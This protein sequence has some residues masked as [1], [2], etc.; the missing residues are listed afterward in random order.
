LKLRTV[1]IGT[2][3][4]LGAVTGAYFVWQRNS[5]T[6]VPV[7][8][9]KTHGRLEATRITISAKNQGRLAE[10]LVREGDT[11]DA[12]QVVARMDARSL[13][14]QLR[15]AEAQ[16]RRTRDAKATASAAVTQR[17]SELT[18]AKRQYDRSR[19]AY[20]MGAGSKQ[21]VDVDQSKSET[22]AAALKSARSQ[23]VEAESAIEAADAE[24]ERLKVEIE[25]CDL[26]APVHARVQYRLAEPGEV[27]AAGGRVLDLIDLTD[28]YMIVYL[29]ETEAG[30][31]ALGAEARVI[32]DAAPDAV[33]PASVSYVAA[34]AQFTPKTVE[35]ATERQKLAFQV[36]VRI[37]ADLLRRYELLVKTG[38]P[39]TVYV[40][41]DSKTEWPDHLRP[42]LPREPPGA[43]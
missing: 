25:D 15:Q 33:V 31:T 3:L 2:V 4:V 21:D 24:V 18:L 29:P 6:D 8:F 26:I 43:K 34:E 12:G 36:R 40:R 32:F 28:A 41:L 11:V 35:T 13:K 39:G 42:Y 9:A 16:A 1:L 30:R 22:A 27:L 17:E 19:Q 7:G 23:V 5:Q 38:L 37:P 14:A 10:V 20:E